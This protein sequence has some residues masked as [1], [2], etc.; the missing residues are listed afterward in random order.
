MASAYLAAPASGVMMA[1]AIAVHNVPEEFAM[2]LPAAALASLRLV[3]AAAVASGPCGAG[4]GCGGPGGA[5]R[6]PGLH[7]VFLA[8]AAGA[9]IFVAAA[10]LVP[11]VG[12]MRSPRWAAVGAVL[13]LAVYL[14]LSR[15]T[16]GQ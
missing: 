14:L 16:G 2:A 15:L 5:A 3:Y 4:R 9:M 7:P 8:V 13:S 10:E 6:W 11:L 12:R 1:V